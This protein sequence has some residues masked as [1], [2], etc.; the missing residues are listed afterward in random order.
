[1]PLEFGKTY[2]MH[3]QQACSSLSPRGHT[4]QFYDQNNSSKRT[5]PHYTQP[6]IQRGR[7]STPAPELG[8]TSIH[9]S[10]HLSLH[11]ISMYWRLPVPALGWAPEMQGQV[12]PCSFSSEPKAET[13]KIMPLEGAAQQSGTFGNTANWV[14]S[15]ALSLPSNATLACDCPQ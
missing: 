13:G 1:M 14:Q 7:N 5:A 10:L 15:P 4:L 11:F 3:G 8:Q 12:K 6:S 9:L 2:L